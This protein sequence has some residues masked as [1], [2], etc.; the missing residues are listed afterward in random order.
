MIEH[1]AIL[2][3]TTRCKG[4]E[5]CVAACKAEHTL[6]HDRP[7]SGQLAVDSLSP[8][9]N[10]TVLRQ[11]NDRFVLQQCRH[12][13]EPACVSACLVGAMQ[14]SPEGPVVYDADKCMGCR[15]CLVACPYGIPRYDWDRPIPLVHKCTMCHHRLR[16]GREPACVEACPE[17]ATVF[18]P[19]EEL[20]REAHRRID[21]NPATYLPRVF[22]EHEIGGTSVLYVSDIPLDFLTWKPDMDE[23][24]LPELTWASLEKVPPVI[25]G[26]A[27]LM[28]G[29]R[30]VIDR[31]RKIAALDAM[32]ADENRHD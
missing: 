24:P 9:R 31:R 18:G 10:C 2:I 4:C 17:N 13:L 27:G 7:W 3:D 14:K 12:C 29:L 30:W 6:R 28:T 11:P 20:L 21:A 26:M 23:R 5:R 16:E 8:T 32:P 22:G 15:Y 19:R 25:V 1:P